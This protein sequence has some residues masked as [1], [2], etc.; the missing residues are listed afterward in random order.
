M[1][2]CKINQ[3]LHASSPVHIMIAQSSVCVG[4]YI[5]IEPGNVVSQYHTEILTVKNW[6]VVQ[7][8][9]NS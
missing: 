8:L 9:R 1:H 2:E 3:V 5:I 7:N 6:K 4:V